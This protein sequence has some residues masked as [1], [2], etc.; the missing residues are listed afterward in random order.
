MIKGLQLWNQTA[1]VG[2]PAQLLDLVQA[3]Y[4]LLKLGV[5]LVIALRVI[6]LWGFKELMYINHV[7]QCMVQ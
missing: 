5:I 6:F 3:V 7:N 1:S 2:A 4:I